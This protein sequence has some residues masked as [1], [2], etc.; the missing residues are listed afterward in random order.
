MD[1]FQE[2]YLQSVIVDELADLTI[3]IFRE[4]SR[5]TIF[6]HHFQGGIVASGRL[7][8]EE[9]R[10]A[11]GISGVLDIHWAIEL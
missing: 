2:R 1:W 9:Q 6:P 8:I 5:P 7:R 10:P 11:C 3:E 4:P